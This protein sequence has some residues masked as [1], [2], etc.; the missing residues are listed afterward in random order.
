MPGIHDV[1]RG[2]CTHFPEV[3][4]VISHGSPDYRVR[5]KS[6]ATFTVNHHGDGKLALLLNTSREAQQV[7]VASAP[8]IFFVPPYVGTRGWVGIDLAQGMRWERV[9]ELVRDAYVRVAPRVLAAEAIPPRKIPRPDT[10]DIRKID[11]LFA[12]KNQALLAKLRAECLALPETAEEQSFGQPVFKAGKKT[13]AQFA[14]YRGIPRAFFW[15][16]P[17]RQASLTADARYEIPPFMGHNGWVS[18]R[19]DGRFDAR[20][21]RGLVLDSY[22]H[23]ALKRML[24]QLD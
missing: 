19:L 4:E 12:P 8:K 18:L 22:K 9:A 21:I 10:L 15:A 6:F 2:I 23:F 13:F 16:G 5:N 7:Y 24:K 20:E 3:V 1:V 17:E 14:C 11:P